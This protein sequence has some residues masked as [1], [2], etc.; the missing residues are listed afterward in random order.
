V[1]FCCENN[2]VAAFTRADA[3]TA[4]GG[5]AARA[6]AI[7]VPAVSVDGN[8]AIA[9][10]AA[11]GA[12]VAEVRRGDGPR[13]VH[14]RTYRLMGHTSTDAAAWRPADEVASARTREPLARLAGVL[15]ERGIATETLDAILA[16]AR[17]EMIF[18]RDG[19]RSA[20]WP[21]PASAFDDVQTTGAVPWPR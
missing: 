19:A 6:E 5:P 15:A 13:L 18:A 7:G 1:L 12:A 17:A 16:D 14:V 3:V 2:G 21:E 20:P 10:D 9:V 11:V 8:D 4:G